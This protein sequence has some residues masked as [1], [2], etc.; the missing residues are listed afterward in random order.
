[1]LI[2]FMYNS[3]STFV[4]SVEHMHSLLVEEVYCSESGL[5]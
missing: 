5:G 4:T 1:M 2:N 3:F